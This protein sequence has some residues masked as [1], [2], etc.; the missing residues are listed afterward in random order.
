MPTFGISMRPGLPT[1]WEQGFKRRCPN[2]EQ[3]CSVSSVEPALEG[4]QRPICLNQ[5]VANASLR[6]VQIE[7]EATELL[8]LD[9]TVIQC[10]K[11]CVEDG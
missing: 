1:E 6:P 8:P 11:K 2:R 3:Y 10:T 4:T 7:D 9:G 5:M